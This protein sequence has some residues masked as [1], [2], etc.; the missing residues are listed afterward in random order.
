[1]TSI[2]ADDDALQWRGRRGHGHPAQAGPT[3]ALRQDPEEFGKAVHAGDIEAQAGLIC[4]FD[5]AAGLFNFLP[6]LFLCCV[7]SGL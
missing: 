5:L 6:K 4:K 1:V 2:R 3:E 7:L